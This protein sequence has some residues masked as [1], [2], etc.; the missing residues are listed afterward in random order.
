MKAW[1]PHLEGACY[2]REDGWTRR[3]PGPDGS[4]RVEAIPLDE[5]HEAGLPEHPDMQDWQRMLVLCSQ[6]FQNLIPR[7]QS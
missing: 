6:P 2:T 7:R 1:P 5:I 3:V 4:V